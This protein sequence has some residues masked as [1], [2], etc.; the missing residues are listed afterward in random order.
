MHDKKNHYIQIFNERQSQLEIIGKQLDNLSIINRRNSKLEKSK[1]KQKS[2]KKKYQKS[3]VKN[4]ENANISKDV[5]LIK[6]NY[7]FVK[8]E[9]QMCVGQILA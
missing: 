5:L 4:I 8:Y 3:L 7:V 2:A 6:G 1:G 9:N